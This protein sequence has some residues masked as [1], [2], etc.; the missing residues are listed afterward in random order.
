ML[1]AVAFACRSATWPT[2]R[3]GG[4]CSSRWR[5]CGASP[6]CAQ[7][8]APS[9]ECAARAAGPAGRRLR[10]ADAAQRDADR[11]RA[12]RRRAAARPGRA[13]GADDVRRARHAARRRRAARS[14]GRRRSPPRPRC[15]RWPLAGDAACSTTGPRSR[16]S[17]RAATRASC[18]LAVRAA[19]DARGDLGRVPALLCKFAIL[20]Y[21]PVMLVH[22]RG[23]TVTQAALVAQRRVARR[24]SREHAGAAGAAPRAGV[25]AAELSVVVV[26]TVAGRLRDRADLGVGAARGRRLRARRRHP[27]GAAELARHRGGACRHAGRAGGGQRHGAQ[28]RQARGAA[29]DGGC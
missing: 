28:R 19:G 15:C 13:A 6:G 18:G 8:W 4:A 21:L 7:A 3:A 24:R 29:R 27:D 26:G 12:A 17:D 2:R 22:G 20:A 9:L 11:G 25:A 16:Q 1:P 10:R 14:R 5:C 23:A